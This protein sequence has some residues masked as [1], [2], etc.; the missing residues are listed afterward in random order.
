MNGMTLD[1]RGKACPQPVI[2]TRQAVEKK[3]ADLTVLVDNAPA[4]ENVR[5]FLEKCGYA[6]E[7]SQPEAS[8]WNVA[9]S[10]GEACAAC[11]EAEAL[12]AEAGQNERASRTLVFLSS[13]V[14]G[15]GSDELGAKLMANFLATLPEMGANLWRIVMVN[16]GVKL[17]SE[18]GRALDALKAL[19]ASGVSIL[20]C[21][22]CLDHFGLLEKKQVG[23]TTN[24]LDIITSLDLAD[25]VIRP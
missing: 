4:S 12:I 25:K 6:V 17:A 8:V 19:E 16:G 3:P 21:G 5:R 11:D 15:S 23:E 24:M 10:A 13:A 1:C 9:A 18:E 20:V 7:V 2:E 22:T 14:I